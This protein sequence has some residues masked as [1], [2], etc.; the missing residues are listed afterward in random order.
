LRKGVLPRLLAVLLASSLA[1][2]PLPAQNLPNL[3]DT[4]RGELSPVM[5]RKL[6]EEIMQ[7]LRRDKD[8]LNDRPLQEYLN[9]LGASLLNAKPE[10][11]GEAAYDFG[12][13]AVRDPMLNAFALPGGFIGVHTGLLLA[14]QN[15]SELAG[16]LAHEIGHV[17]QRHIARMLGSQRSDSLI[18]LAAMLLA[19]LAARSNSDI[20]NAAMMGGTGLAVQRQLNFSREAEREADRVGLQI[21][22][23][24]GFD[25][26]GMVAF[27]GRLQTASRGY[28]ETAPAYLRTHPLTTE[29]M[30]DI[31]GRILNDR[32]RQHADTPDFQLM[33]ARAR[34]LQDSS[35]Q[36]LREAAAYFETQ[37]QQKARVQAQAAR[38]GLAVIALRQGDAARAQSLFNEIRGPEKKLAS[39]T[40]TSMEI[41][42]ASVARRNDEA[43]KLADAAR[44]QYP[45][46]R[47]IAMQYG[48]AL[49]N[50][51]RH[52]EA[53]RYLRDQAQLYRQEAELQEMLARAYAAQGK[54]ALQHMALAE[55]YALKGGLPAALDQLGM[56]R[57]APDA[58]FYDQ[59]VIDAREREFKAKRL[60][61]INEKKEK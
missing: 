8:Y 27:F 17:S 9:S 58:S 61:Q 57:R 60:D 32:Y 19:V 4:E 54:N 12:F 29:R 1:V 35:P 42:I 7:D 26:S 56:A 13:F 24:G 53:V 44:N 59:S 41:E 25:A 31:Q 37:L 39:Q 38:Y 23:D 33:R 5:E 36:G 45:L 51:G 28:S 18:P 3:G 40:L 48:Q 43:L 10:T 2:A 55:A 11:R 6:G 16:V 50:A 22:R 47:G 52:E 30:A 20:S 15:E 34:V 46:S 49:V 14:A 21:L